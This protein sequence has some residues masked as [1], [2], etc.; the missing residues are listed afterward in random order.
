MTS[1]LAGFLL[2][3]FTAAAILSGNAVAAATDGAVGILHFE[4]VVDVAGTAEGGGAAAPT[5][6]FPLSFTTLGRRF[7]LEL[8]PSDVLVPG[9]KTVWVGTETVT[10]AVPTN[11]LF[12]GRLK[13]EPESWVRITLSGGEMEGIVWTPTETYFLQPSRDLIPGGA[14]GATVAYRLSDRDPNYVPGSCAMEAQPF[15]VNGPL[16][17]PSAGTANVSIPAGDGG[18]A[19]AA[20]LETEM[21]IVGDYEYYVKHG[22]NSQT[23]LATLLNLIDAIYEVELGVS[24]RLASIVVFTTSSDQF[25]GTTDYGALL[26]DFSRFRSVSKYCQGRTI[27]YCQGNSSLSC[28]SDADCGGSGPCANNTCSTDTQCGASAPCVSNVIYGTDL[29]HL[30]TGRNLNS[31]VIGIAW[32]GALCSSYYGAGL[33]EDFSNDDYMLT[34]VMAHEI[35]HNFGAPHDNQSGSACGYEPFGWIMN[36]YIS[37]S[38]ADQF[39]ACSKSTI[40][41]EVSSATCLSAVSGGTPTPTPTRAN[42][43][44]PTWTRVPTATPTWSPTQTSTRTPTRTPTRNGTPTDTPVLPTATWTKAN[45]PAPTA[46]PPLPTA[47]WTQANTPA[48]TNTPGPPPVVLARLAVFRDGSWLVDNGNRRWDGCGV[49]SCVG[50]FGLAGDQPVVGDWD[51]SGTKKLGVFRGMAWYLDNGNGTWD[52]CGVDRCWGPFG[53]PGDTP[54]VGDWN[55]TGTTKIGVYRASGWFLDNGNGQWDGCGVDWCLSSFGLAGDQAVAGPWQGGTVPQV[56]V[57]RGI[58]WFLD[59]GNVNWDGCGLD[60]CA[61]PFGL[62]GDRAVAGDWDGDGAAEIGV[63]RAG[64]WFLDDGNAKWDGCSVDSCVPSFGLAGDKA[65]AW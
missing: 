55:G 13:D 48:P 43:G 50:P 25:N 10:T 21:G 29:A 53:L 17:G 52:G 24:L 7:D 2:V 37:S 64:Q 42:T 11:L 27:R 51:G 30:V 58:A 1:R 4:S 6:T 33:S 28:A 35:G 59:N 49:D 23:K 12:R 5:A 54:V 15:R 26:D 39:S 45:T 65:V 60:S 36:P 41:P 46:T 8:E 62:P 38:L 57:Y 47:T 44:T 34:L 63:F 20:L 56:G 3:G 18:A 40:G 32:L 9:A 19:Q 31:S 14:P 22:A 16:P 61:G